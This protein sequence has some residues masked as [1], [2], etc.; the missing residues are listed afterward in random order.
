MKLFQ[1][2]EIKFNMEKFIIKLND[3]KKKNLLPFWF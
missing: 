1:E 3:K 2:N